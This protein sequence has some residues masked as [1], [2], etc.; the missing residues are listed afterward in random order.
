MV[1]TENKIVFQL[2][3]SDNPDTTG[4]VF[5]MDMDGSNLETLI[6][7]ASQLHGTDAGA[8]YLSDSEDDIVY[9]LYKLDM[10]TMKTKT[11]LEDF[12]RTQIAKDGD[13]LYYTD[14]ERV[15]EENKLELIRLN[16]K[17]GVS[18]SLMKV[19]LVSYDMGPQINVKDG[20]I[21]Y[22]DEQQGCIMK[23][24]AEGGEPQKVGG[25]MYSL[26]FTYSGGAVYC[27][28]ND[29]YLNPTNSWAVAE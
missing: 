14:S 7:E 13:W 22:V 29:D 27:T 1:L 11:L 15:A 12:S 28:T 23:R 8:L 4:A 21:Y 24:N 20:Q 17:T 10:D 6:G 2:S 9:R 25:E 18:E 19:D 5:T 16:E 26:T 3:P